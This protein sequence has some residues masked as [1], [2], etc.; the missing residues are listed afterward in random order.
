[1]VGPEVQRP[2]G[3]DAPDDAMDHAGPGPAGDRAR[4]LEEGEVR[5]GTRE[6]VAIEEVVDARVVLVDRLC[7]QP[8]AEDARVVVDVARGVAR[9]RRDVVDT[10]EVHAP[11]PSR[12][13]ALTSL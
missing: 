3:R 9:D 8:Q 1:M 13:L 5:A 12:I 2:L 10:V 4:I 7:G 6:L 11:T